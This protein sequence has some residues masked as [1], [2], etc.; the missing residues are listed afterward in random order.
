MNLI[1]LRS[2][3]MTPNGRV[4]LDDRQSRHVRQVLRSKVGDGL[5]LGR[6]RGAIGRG[7][8]LRVDGQNIK[9]QLDNALRDSSTIA[10]P[11]VS[12]VL[13]LPRPKVLSRVL[14]SAAALGVDRIDLVNAW[15]VEKSYFQSKRL[16][17]QALN[18]DLTLGCEQGST[19]WI[20]DIQVHPLLMPFL[21]SLPSASGTRI[22][23]HPRAEAFLEDAVLP[24]TSISIA[25]GPDRGWIDAELDSFAEI[26]FAAV[27]LGPSVMRVETA[28]SVMLGGLAIL[29]RLRPSAPG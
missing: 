29:Q 26:G 1:L 14:Q 24:G 16:T 23:A 28:V 4:L 11:R 27:S 8:V 9:L 20:P 22:I 15:R 19:T 7:E 17:E 2:S 6:V 25:I 10:P 3:Q 5:R 12:L 21:R 18:A 13:A